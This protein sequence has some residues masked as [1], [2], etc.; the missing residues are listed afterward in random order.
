[1]TK[2]ASFTLVDQNLMPDVSKPLAVNLGP[3]VANE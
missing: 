1:M 3:Q 2:P